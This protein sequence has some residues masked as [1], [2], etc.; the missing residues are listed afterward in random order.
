MRL[1]HR[2]STFNNGPLTKWSEEGL[3]L[4][5][6]YREPLDAGVVKIIDAFELREPIKVEV[7]DIVDRHLLNR[8]FVVWASAFFN[9]IRKQKSK[10]RTKV[11]I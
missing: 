11:P 10:K 7:K 9:S 6:T 4:L 5:E 2:G 1:T 3:M 8:F